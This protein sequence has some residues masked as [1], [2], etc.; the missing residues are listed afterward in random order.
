MSG[1]R[2]I[3][4]DSVI[5][6]KSWVIL[7]SQ[8][9]IYLYYQQSRFFSELKAS[10]ELKTSNF[11][12]LIQTFRV[13]PIYPFPSIWAVKKKIIH[14]Y[15][16]QEFPHE[17]YYDFWLLKFRYFVSLIFLKI[18]TRIYFQIKIKFYDTIIK[19]DR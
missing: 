6:Q 5:I 18:W 14:L 12:I 13:Y 10:S 17:S 9:L 1:W 3:V 8:T 19:D 11:S 7:N 4:W 15:T 16:Y 2:D